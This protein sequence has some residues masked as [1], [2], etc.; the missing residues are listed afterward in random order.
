MP[1]SSPARFSFVVAIATSLDSGLEIASR[2]RSGRRAFGNGHR[3]WC[4]SIGLTV[5][6]A[7]WPNDT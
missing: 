4:A 6:R 1:P 2:S 5:V 7:F 3:E